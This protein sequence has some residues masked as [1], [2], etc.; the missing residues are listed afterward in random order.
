[1]GAGGRNPR[2]PA[3]AKCGVARPVRN[4]CGVGDRRRAI[5]AVALAALVALAAALVAGSRDE[6]PP[7]GEP[8][9]APGTDAAAPGPSQ[10]PGERERRRPRPGPNPDPDPRPDEVAEGPS[11]PRPASDPE[12]A[13]ARRVRAYV[14]A[15]NRRDGKRLCAMLAPGALEAIE[16][17]RERRSCPATLRASLGYRDPRGLPVWRRSHV[18]EAISAEV[19]G[20]EARVVATVF[21][22]Y[23]DEREPTI[24]D[25]I[26]FLRRDGGR[27]LLAKPSATLYRAVGIADP[28]LSVLTPP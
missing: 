11:G 23:A 10:P 22:T 9:A 26:V 2:D 18:T 24:E 1:M 4:S 6:P 20:A 3:P 12:R 25:D 17:P 5:A 16:L 21:T 15:L 7:V 27:W 14:A 13:A 8:A 19:S 28:P